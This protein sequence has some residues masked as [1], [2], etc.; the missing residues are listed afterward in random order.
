MDNR[1]HAINMARGCVPRI[2]DLV[3]RVPNEKPG[4]NYYQS[5]LIRALVHGC[6]MARNCHFPE[7]VEAIYVV[8]E[9]LFATATPG[10][11]DAHN[12]GHMSIV[13][14]VAHV[15]GMAVSSPEAFPEMLAAV[16]PMVDARLPTTKQ[17]MNELR[18]RLDA[19]THRIRDISYRVLAERN[20]QIF[21][22]TMGQ[23]I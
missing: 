3:V 17:Q 13:R 22:R 6:S 19:S 9:H 15:A 8:T 16:Q 12:E 20:Q 21:V 18:A 11:F 5:A 23:R 4:D 2:A 10:N 7:A 1:I 14:E